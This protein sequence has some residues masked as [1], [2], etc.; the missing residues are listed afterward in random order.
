MYTHIV[1]GARLPIPEVAVRFGRAPGSHASDRDCRER[2]PRS[3]FLLPPFD[4]FLT[5][6]G[7]LMAGFAPHETAFCKGFCPGRGANRRFFFFPRP[8]QQETPEIPGFSKGVGILTLQRSPLGLAIIS[9]L[10]SFYVASRSLQYTA[11]I[12]GRRQSA[13][14][15]LRSGHAL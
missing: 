7:A 4:P 15:I 2:P 6:F 1:D 12:A 3:W 9:I 11:T 13:C 8:F 14:R 5:P 10:C